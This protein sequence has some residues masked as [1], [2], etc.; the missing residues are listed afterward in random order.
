M[1]KAIFNY[2]NNGDIMFDCINHAEDHDA[3]TI[4]STLSNVLV[5]ACFRAGSEPTIYNKGHVRIDLVHADY[6]IAEV[7]RT[8]ESVMRKAEEQHPDHIRI[9]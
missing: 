9:Y 2:S 5:E 1:T 6:P 3:C 8:V 4:M 7:F